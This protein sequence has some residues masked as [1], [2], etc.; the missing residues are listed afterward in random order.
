MS[1]KLFSDWSVAN[2]PRSHTRQTLKPLNPF[3]ITTSGP[4]MRIIRPACLRFPSY[5]DLLPLLSFLKFSSRQLY[6]SQN[7]DSKR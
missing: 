4:V 2:K 6:A 3:A 1:R 7:F 5:L